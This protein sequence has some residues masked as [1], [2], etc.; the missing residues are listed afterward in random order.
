MKAGWYEK[1]GEARDVLVVGEMETPKAGPGEVLVRLR[2][3]G[4]N[5]SDVKSRKAR[6]LIAPRI[7][8]HSDGAGVIE[9]VGEGVATARIGERVFIWNGQWKR[10]FGTAAEFIAVPNGQ[11]V[12]LAEAVDF[13]AGACLGIPALTALHAVKLHGDIAGKTLLV[14]GA[15]ASVGHYAVQIAKLAGAR[16]IGTASDSRRDHALDAGCDEVIDYRAEDVVA[17]VKDLTGGKGAD[18]IIDMDLSSTAA[19]LPGGVL[20]PHGK[21]VCYGSNVAADV[22]VSFPALLWG[23]LTLQVFVVYELTTNERAV[24]LKELGELLDA[25]KLR[26]AIGATFPIDEIAAAHEA[27]EQGQ[28]IGNVVLRVD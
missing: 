23:S 7:V 9:A 26:H 4:V 12:R 15:A 24:R 13:D 8:P 16:V 28:I 5:P 21:L 11:A 2:T 20:V 25:G 22:P 14:T 18:G 27:V 6:P 10:A 3:S 17:R 19:L 1:N